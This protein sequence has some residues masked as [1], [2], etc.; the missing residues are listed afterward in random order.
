V[1]VSIICSVTHTGPLHSP[2]KQVAGILGGDQRGFLTENLHIYVFRISHM[3]ATCLVNHILLHLF[4]P[5]IFNEHYVVC[6]TLSTLLRPAP[7]SRVQIFPTA[8]CSQTRSACVLP[9]MR[10]SYK[11]AGKI[12]LFQSLDIRNSFTM[13]S[14]GI[15]D[16][17]K[18]VFWEGTPSRYVPMFRGTCSTARPTFISDYTV[19]HP[20]K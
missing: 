15:G 2:N 20:R 4:I 9:V 1:S 10:H 12:S 16:L 3:R 14:S 7:P 11:T 19:S 18:L 8:P 17:I 6:T 13:L 5:I